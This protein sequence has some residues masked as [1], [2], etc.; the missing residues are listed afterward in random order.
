MY[1]IMVKVISISEDVYEGLKDLKDEKESF[2]Q[3]I[4]KLISKEKRKE[5]LS[6]SGTWKEN[7]EIVKAMNS[8]IKDRKNFRLRI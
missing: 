5:L 7:N 1:I 6:L 3:V 8:I 4:R 2:S